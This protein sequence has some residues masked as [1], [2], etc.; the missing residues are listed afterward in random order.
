MLFDF[1]QDFLS[2]DL[3]S[4]L[5]SSVSYLPQITAIKEASILENLN[6]YS[7]HTSLPQSS[8]TIISLL[9][10]LKLSSSSVNIHSLSTLISDSGPLSGGQLQRISLARELMIPRP[11]M[12]MD[13]P[14]SALDKSTAHSVIDSLLSVSST[15]H[16]II[17]THQPNLFENMNP[18]ILD[19]DKHGR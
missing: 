15:S 11:L 7:P 13:E 6:F 17:S 1:S 4:T 5:T 12:I 10:T 19:L 16:F 3:Y 18:I 2:N 14:T 9:N 8:E